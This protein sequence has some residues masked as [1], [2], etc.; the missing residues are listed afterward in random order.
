[1]RRL[2]PT[3]AVEPLQGEE[4]EEKEEDITAWSALLLGLLLPL[5]SLPVLAKTRSN[6][7]NVFL[8]F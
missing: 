1:M 8:L 7:T 6:I 5:K 3:R 4:E 2:R